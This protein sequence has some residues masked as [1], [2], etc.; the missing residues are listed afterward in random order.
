MYHRRKREF[1]VREEIDRETQ[2]EGRLIDMCSVCSVS[3]HNSMLCG[4]Q[5]LID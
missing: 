4:S 2:R 1:H 5:V 3:C